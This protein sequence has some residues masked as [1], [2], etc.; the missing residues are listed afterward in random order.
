MTPRLFRTVG[1]VTDRC[2]LPWG[3]RAVLRCLRGKNASPAAREA[4]EGE[5]W[6]GWGWPQRLRHRR[7]RGGGGA[8][9]RTRGRIARRV[10]ELL[11]ADGC[12]EH[13]PFVRLGEDG[14]AVQV[15]GGGSR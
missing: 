2:G 14:R 7:R 15:V 10:R 11:P 4:A 12:F 5:A 13:Q 1:E 9:G 3:E 8:G 6:L